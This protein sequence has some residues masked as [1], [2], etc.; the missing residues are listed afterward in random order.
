M[1][2]MALQISEP[3]A[4]VAAD[5]QVFALALEHMSGQQSIEEQDFRD[6]RFDFEDGVA[7][8]VGDVAVLG[9][10]N[11]VV[12]A[13]DRLALADANKNLVLGEVVDAAIKRQM[14]FPGHHVVRQHPVRVFVEQVEL[15]KNAVVVKAR[16]HFFLDVGH[17]RRRA[18]MAEH[19][20][21]ESGQQAKTAFNPALQQRSFARVGIEAPAAQQAQVV[22]TIVLEPPRV[23]RGRRIE[24]EDGAH[25]IAERFDSFLDA[26]GVSQHLKQGRIGFTHTVDMQRGRIVVVRRAREQPGRYSD[27]VGAMHRGRR[28][29]LVVHAASQAISVP[30][31]STTEYT[32]GGAEPGVWGLLQGR[33]RLSHSLHRANCGV[34]V[35]TINRSTPYGSPTVLARAL[36]FRART[37]HIPRPANQPNRGNLMSL[38]QIAFYGKGGIGKSTT[39]QNTLAALADLDQKILI[40]GCDPKADSTR[41]IQIGR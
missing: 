33:S 2:C 10:G 7:E 35:S 32:G 20:L 25:V 16:R 3:D 24:F 22:G 39:S 37:G 29:D 36:R 11:Q 13:R 28:I 34:T 19:Y 38:R 15:Q 30:P 31:P 9:E 17:P 27:E 40:V 26:S 12:L 21:V 4:E 5:Y 6:R 14:R 18:I 41:L 8:A 23:A 1:T